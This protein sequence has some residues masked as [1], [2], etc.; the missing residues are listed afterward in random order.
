MISI[1]TAP[2]PL[3]WPSYFI[4]IPPNRPG[5]SPSS[6]LRRN[7]ATIRQSK[8]LGKTQLDATALCRGDSRSRLQKAQATHQSEDATALRRGD[9]RSRLQKNVQEIWGC[10]GLVP[11]RLTFIAE[12]Q[13]LNTKSSKR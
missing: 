9:S 13:A 8:R 6:G 10:H 12:G 1:P 2:A 7:Q 5:T 11:W 3:R 4:A